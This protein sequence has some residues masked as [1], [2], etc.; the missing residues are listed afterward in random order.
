MPDTDNLRPADATQ[1]RELI[2]W[3]AAEEH[4]LEIVGTGT[5]RTVGRPMQTAHLASLAALAGIRDYAP[6][7]LVLTAGPGTPMAEIATALGQA[8]Q[9]LAFEP[10]DLGPLLGG[11]AGGGTLGGA[12]SANLAGPRRIKA[13]AARDHFLGFSGVTG[14]GEAFKAGGRVVKNVTGYDICK[15][16]T[17][18]WGTLVALDEVS[19]KVLPAPEATAS[20]VLAGLSDDAA[21]RAMSAALN[22]SH[23]VSGAAHLPAGIA[24]RSPVKPVAAAGDA[25]TAI[26]LEGFAPSVAARVAALRDELAGHGNVDVLEGDDALALW[27]DIRD[28]GALAPPHTAIDSACVWRVSVTPTLG[29]DVMARVRDAAEAQGYY[30]WG[31]GLLWIA[32]SGQPDGGAGAVR[33]AVAAAGTPGQPA[34]HA[35]LIRAPQAVRAAVDVFQPQAPALAGLGARLKQQF[36]PNGVLNPGRMVPGV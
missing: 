16:V 6:E 3:A 23:D 14:R 13:G 21:Q 5:L 28:V 12:I 22:S 15:L 9:Q 25:V 34:G 18:A 1:L 11:T 36:D 35:T 26:R 29:A 31:G 19:V 2:A 7:E 8:R 32:V 30:D 27:A 17:G 4:P 10:P 20:L 24:A 33:D